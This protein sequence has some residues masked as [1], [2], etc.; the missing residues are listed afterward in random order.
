MFLDRLGDERPTLDGVIRAMQPRFPELPRL[1]GERDG[2]HEVRLLARDGSAHLTWSPAGERLRIDVEPVEPQTGLVEVSTEELEGIHSELA[3]LRGIAE[4]LPF[5]VWRE[6]EAGQ[7]T[8][9]NRGYVELC[10]TA[11]GTDPEQLWPIPR[12][13]DGIGLGRDGTY[14]GRHWIGSENENGQPYQVTGTRQGRGTMYTAIAADGAV[15][16]EKAL[17]GLVQTLTKTFAQISIG[18][19]V[20]SAERRMVLFNPALADLTGLSPA[21]LARQPLLTAFLDMLRD[22]RMVPEPRDYKAWRARLAGVGE[23]THG[24]GLSETWH[25][26][27]GRS[28]HVTAIPQ[29]G[30]ALALIVEDITGQVTQNRSFRGTLEMHQVLLDRRDEALA[31]FAPDGAMVLCNE[32]Y[33]RLWG[34][35]HADS[36]VPVRLETSLETW[37]ARAVPTP[38]W[39]RFP[40]DH[41]TAAARRGSVLNLALPDGRNLEC[42]VSPF[43]GGC[44]LVEFLDPGTKTAPAPTEPGLRLLA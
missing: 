16:T 39:E 23:D 13:F 42:R 11:L 28:F 24:D 19:A 2:Q 40:L 21:T 4:D 31:V 30:G 36:P 25:I 37:K 9:V 29:P 10:R 12:V 14:E 17:H 38:E 15:S 27:D 43:P 1:L 34:T 3:I 33:D 5:A 18:L 22:Q 6:D 8:W 32:A 20:F 7:V 26:A 44:L 35:S 41:G